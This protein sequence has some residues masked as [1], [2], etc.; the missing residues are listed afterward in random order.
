[1]K[2]YS[3]LKV[4]IAILCMAMMVAG[5]GSSSATK[6]AESLRDN[7][8][9]EDDDV[10]YDDEDEDY[11]DKVK[12][13]IKDK[14][15]DKEDGD[16]RDNTRDEVDT[17]DEVSRDKERA[18]EE[19]AEAYDLGYYDGLN[20]L[21][22][23][24]GVFDGSK[25]YANGYTAGYDDGYEEYK[26]SL[27][28]N[29]ED[30]EEYTKQEIYDEG[31]TDGYYDGSNDLTYDD[32]GYTYT[33]KYDDEYKKGYEEGYTDGYSEIMDKSTDIGNE[34][35]DTMVVGNEKVGY[36]Q[37]PANYV[38]L[39][40]PSYGEDAVCYC[41]GTTYNIMCLVYYDVEGL[42]AMQAAQNLA[43]GIEYEGG[44]TP[45]SFLTSTVQLGGVE[46]YQICA[47]YPSSNQW[48]INWLFESPY[49]D[50]VHYASVE[51]VG[52]DLTLFN[53]MENTYSFTE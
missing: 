44:F 1:M 7:D 15:K 9:Y 3:K 6:L 43:A 16:S 40:E 24:Y 5:C 22:F 52:E 20:D 47:Y 27:E 23:D 28:D 45:E 13:K 18:D 19:Y 53:L 25:N 26:K 17:R 51:F 33:K 35:T 21:G 32:S 29:K 4:L 46:A 37:V 34:D 42:T 12:D 50:Y 39:H 48:L 2:K 38:K 30:E 11:E 49:D 14:D 10:D 41:D 8:S 36:V 31:Y